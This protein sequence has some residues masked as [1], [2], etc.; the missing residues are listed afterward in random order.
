[1]KGKT[2]QVERFCHLG[3]YIRFK[4]RRSEERAARGR[5]SVSAFKE[6]TV[7][8]K[9][10]LSVECLSIEGEKCMKNV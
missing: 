8:A 2:E 10:I 9:K 3:G 7:E 1:M 5:K 4:N 6:R